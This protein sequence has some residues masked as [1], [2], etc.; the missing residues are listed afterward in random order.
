PAAAAPPSPWQRPPSVCPGP[1]RPDPPR[2]PRR[3][4]PPRF[5]PPRAE[6]AQLPVLR[7]PGRA[8]RRARRRRTP[9]PDRAA[10]RAGGARPR[11]GAGRAAGAGPDD[12][13]A[14]QAL[15]PDAFLS[16]RVTRPDGSATRFPVA[17]E[18][19]RGT[20]DRRAW[21]ARA[22]AYLAGYGDGHGPLLAAFGVGS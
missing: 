17:L 14:R 5:P 22:R 7:P 9:A 13:G 8:R 20:V 11:P 3:R 10:A 16:V 18:V 1:L 15:V 2:G 21:Q 12:G 6:A 4:R 19:D